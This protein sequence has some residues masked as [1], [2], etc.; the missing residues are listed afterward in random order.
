MR[1]TNL[2]S[3]PAEGGS[4]LRQQ[5]VRGSVLV[6]DDEPSIR[7]LLR[8]LL[9]DEGYEV[10]V[11]EDGVAALGALAQ[12]TPDVMLLDLAMPRMSGYELLAQWAPLNAGRTCVIVLSA[13]REL[14]VAA[15]HGA[16]VL[17]KPFDLDEVLR[18]VDGIRQPA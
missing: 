11:A 17:R 16:T 4:A 1:S 15:L 10:R 5:D 18:T 13:S 7:H 6:V 9:S 3:I 14:D 2:A 12:W 8:E